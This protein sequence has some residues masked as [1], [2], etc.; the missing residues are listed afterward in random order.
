MVSSTVTSSLA[1]ALLLVV[2]FVFLFFLVTQLL[3][4]LCFQVKNFETLIKE[5][6]DE[7]RTRAELRRAAEQESEEK[8]AQLAS[9]LK[10]SEEKREEER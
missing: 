3:M 10:L 7:M 9:N 5:K 2:N 1:G 4:H 8:A 6:D